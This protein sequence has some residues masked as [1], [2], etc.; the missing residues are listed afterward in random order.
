MQ[1]KNF[2]ALALVALAQFSVGVFANSGYAASCKNIQIYPP[3][4]NTNYWKIAADCTNNA[5]Q[6]NLNT[7]I[8]IDSCFS[9]SNGSLVAQLNGSFGSSCT[10]VILT[11]TVLSASCRNTAGASINTSIDTNNV[12]GNANGALY[13]FNQG[14]L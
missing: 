14:A 13:C 6:T 12:I 2:A 3:D 7:K 4:G 1:T 10:N 5:Q 9:N 11:G 8:N